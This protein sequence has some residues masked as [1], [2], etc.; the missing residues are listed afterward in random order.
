[1]PPIAVW[2]KVIALGKEAE[3]TWTRPCGSVPVLY[4][5]PRRCPSTRSVASGLLLVSP[6]VAVRPWYTCPCRRHIYS[7]NALSFY[8]H[9]ISS[10]GCPS[11]SWKS[12]KKSD[13]TRRVRTRSRCDR[14]GL[15]SDEASPGPDG[16]GL[17]PGQKGRDPSSDVALPCVLAW[18]A[19]LCTCK[20]LCRVCSS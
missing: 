12:Y 8:R 14:G 1:V 11:L 3:K 20:S 7:S 15:M 13:G 5:V 9:V 18:K 2:P 19:R 10:N 17:M 4:A 6:H 16:E